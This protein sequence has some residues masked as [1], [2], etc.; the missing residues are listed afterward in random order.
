MQS[1]RILP[2]ALLA[3]VLAACASSPRV[4]EAGPG[5][6][7]PSAAVER[8]L[9][10]ANERSYAEMAWVFGTREG[11]YARQVPPRDAELLMA[12]HSCLL[13][14]ERSAIRDERPVPGTTGEAVNYSV[15]LTRE[16]WEGSVPFRVVRGPEGRWFVE[17]VALQTLT[18]S[19]AKVP[20]ECL[21]LMRSLRAR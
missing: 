14:H 7:A 5:A 11:P 12:L 21:T 10:L 2:L 20:E 8:Y 9:R 6:P 3:L 19:T 16:G 13:R 4:P 1:I 15:L 17:D 18:S